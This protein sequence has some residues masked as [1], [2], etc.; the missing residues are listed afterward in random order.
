M[1]PYFTE[2]ACQNLL[3]RNGIHGQSDY[4]K[5]L[6]REGFRVLAVASKEIT[7]EKSIYTMDDETDLTL[8]GFVAFIDPPKENVQESLAMLH[9]AG[10]GV[11]IIT[12]DNELVTR[13]VCTATRLPDQP[14][15]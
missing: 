2:G 14:D 5:T 1:Y 10:I 15:N 8:H 12:G 9:D 11:K 13:H 4:T 6:S 7:D 3:P